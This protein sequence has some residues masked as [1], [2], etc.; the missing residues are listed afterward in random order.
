MLSC[1]V[2]PAVSSGLM[3]IFGCLSLRTSTFVPRY[4]ALSCT[5]ADTHGRLLRQLG[6]WRPGIGCDA[7]CRCA[8][9]RRRAGS[10][11]ATR[12][13]IRRHPVL[14]RARGRRTADGRR[15]N[16]SLLLSNSPIHS[17]HPASSSAASL[18]TVR[19]R[20]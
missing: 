7:G 13:L 1:T 12:D 5:N 6:P 17:H 18:Y 20:G 2:V 14:C 3:V 4:P 11:E 15:M 16:P 19:P 10:R 8:A 9:T